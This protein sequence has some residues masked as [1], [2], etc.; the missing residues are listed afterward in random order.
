MIRAIAKNRD[1]SRAI[2]KP[3]ST[4]AGETGGAERAA[5]RSARQLVEPAGDDLGNA[6][7]L[8]LGELDAGEPILDP[9]DL[10]LELAER[11]H[12]EAR[13]LARREGMRQAHA[14][15]ARRKVEDAAREP[16]RAKLDLPPP[17]DFE[18]VILPPIDRVLRVSF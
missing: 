18:A 13:R 4:V 11:R 6:G 8:G 16:L 7:V 15:T 5:S 12:G 2:R 10:A 9:R 3:Y 17:Q 14:R 1:R